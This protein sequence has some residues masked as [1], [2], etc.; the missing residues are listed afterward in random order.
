[1]IRAWTAP[2]SLRAVPCR[3]MFRNI[4]PWTMGAVQDLEHPKTTHLR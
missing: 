1:M 3:A 2:I 4:R